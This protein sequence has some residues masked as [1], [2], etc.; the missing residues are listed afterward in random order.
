[1]IKLALGLMGLLLMGAASSQHAAA[2]EEFAW[3]NDIDQGLCTLYYG[4][5]PV[6]QYFYKVDNSTEEAAFDTA[7]VF[8]HV[9]GPGTTTIITK[10]AGGTFPHHRALYI[11]W[12]KTSYQGKTHD[13]WHCRKGE[14]QRHIDFLKLEGDQQQGTM[15][16]LIHW[17]DPQEQVVVEEQRTLRVQKMPTE[18]APGYGWQI[19]WGT[20]LNSKVGP[21]RLDGDRQHAGFQYRAAQH[22]ADTNNARYIRPTGHPQDPA[23]Y[24]VSDSSDPDK[25][26]DLGWLAMTYELDGQNYTVE[27]LEQPNVPNPSRYSERPYG[28][29]GA[30]FVAELDQDQPLR[31]QYRL[32]ITRGTPPSQQAIQNRYDAFVKELQKN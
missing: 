31:M 5:Q 12:N 24:Q 6:V 27:Y 19:D 17:I 26:V 11:G 10:G 20:Q 3:K 30:F 15:T 21:I 1:M 29:F 13:F 7:K 18:Q 16:A 4:E 22:V 28:R 32:N 23:A 9:Y 2:A 14:R 25:H 8:H